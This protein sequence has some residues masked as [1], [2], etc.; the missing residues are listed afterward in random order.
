MITAIAILIALVMVA[1]T[2]CIL[3]LAGGV[4]IAIAYSDL[5][6]CAMAL[7]IIFKILKRRINKKH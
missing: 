2:A 7:W 5:I 4:A 3:A 6:V 1:A